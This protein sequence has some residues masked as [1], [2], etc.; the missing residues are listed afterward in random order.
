MKKFLSV[1]FILISAHSLFAQA[2]EAINYQT[3]VRNSSGAVIANQPVKLGFL[4]HDGGPTG[5]V[6]YGE[7]DSGETNQFGLFTTSIGRGVV[8]GASF[9]SIN[10]STGHKYLE[11]DYYTGPTTFIQM[12]IEELLSVPY[13]LFAA[14]GA[15]GATGANGATGPTGANGAPGATGPTGIGTAGAAGPTGPTGSNG[16]AGP[17]GPTGSNGVTGPTGAGIVGVTGPTGAQGAT[18]AGG[19]ATGP[20]GAN[21]L[22]GPTGAN[23]TP[24]A[25]GPTG[26]GT[27]GVT[28]PTGTNGTP[29]ATGPT[30]VGIAGATGTNGTAGA[31][32][33]TG[34]GTT[35]PTGPT[36]VGTAGATGPTGATGVGTAGATG[37]TG[38]AT[39]GATG[40]TGNDGATGPTGVGIA[41]P[42][43][44]TGLGTAGATGPTGVG[45][46]GP[47]GPTGTGGLGNGTAPGNTTYWNG[48]IWVLNS[49]NI[50]NDG[51][52]VGIGTST[53]SVLTE[54]SGAVNDVL[55]LTST[56]G[57]AGNHTYL[58]FLTYSGTAVS[59]R[60]GSLDMGSNNGSLVFE[61]GNQG[62][63]SNTTTERM[64]IVN[65]GQVCINTTTPVASL[66]V[67]GTP[68][69]GS[70]SGGQWF[71][72]SG[73]H[74]GLGTVNG[75]V[76][77]FEGDL[78][79]TGSYC[80]GSSG[81]TAS[82]DLRIKKV[83]GV[84]DGI[85]DLSTLSQIQITDYHYIDSISAGTT[86]QKKVIAQQVESVYPQ[87]VRLRFDY[88]PDMYCVAERADFDATAKTLKIHVAK[89]HTLKKGDK[90]Q[91]IDE[92]GERHYSDVKE[93]Q[94]T[95]TFSVSADKQPAK[96]FVFGK[97]VSDF[98]S[99]DYD[100]ISML[101]VSATQELARQL[102]DAQAQ[103]EKLK[104]EKDQLN[105][106]LNEIKNSKA[107]AS[108]VEELKAQIELLRSVML[109]TGNK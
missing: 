82:S 97:G 16:T 59:A 29:G 37:P 75:M 33:P 4:I 87:A 94:D 90:V 1:V 7:I 2:P 65:T 79:T 13:A 20:T 69:S 9:T 66:T 43:G 81:F 22:T 71:N 98:R 85:A 46:A 21:G 91:W 108:Q 47:T 24:G 54:I 64:R 14:N 58:D 50:Y 3:V 62:T 84:S 70:V 5:T 32:G 68:P 86:P 51:A 48:S 92:N 26:I 31:T 89:D 101:N 49:S 72:S 88:I 109:T 57:G 8:S 35:G 96:V 17:T 74:T 78:L 107:D 34:T 42:T 99:V 60:I 95:K 23:G 12:G 28:G 104:S 56:N 76:A 93:A 18:G 73:T 39:A 41:G 61:T 19:G 77:Y 53:P 30:G 80:A 10:W 11:T 15:A 67:G 102:K 44:P 106:T 45:V 103:I 6:V 27:A 40:P 83:H 55:K 38:L 36:G 105:S 63:A 25:T 100:A 52:N